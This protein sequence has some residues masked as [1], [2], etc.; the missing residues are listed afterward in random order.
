MPPERV[1]GWAARGSRSPEWHWRWHATACPSGSTKRRSASWRRRGRSWTLTCGA[2]NGRRRSAGFPRRGPISRATSGR[3]SQRNS[4]RAGEFFRATN[5][6]LRKRMEE[7]GAEI[8]NF[9]W[10][11][12]PDS[13]GDLCEMDPGN[14]SRLR[15]RLDGRME[16]IVI[17]NGRGDAGNRLS[18]SGTGADPVFFL[19]GRKVTPKR[20]RRWNSLRHRL[21]H[22]AGSTLVVGGAMARGGPGRRGEDRLEV[23]GGER[24]RTLGSGRVGAGCPEECLTIWATRPCSRRASRRSEMSCDSRR[25]PGLYQRQARDRSEI[26]AYSR[27]RKVRIYKNDAAAKRCLA[28]RAGRGRRDS[29]AQIGK[30]EP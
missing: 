19:D 18:V 10:G 11:R 14:W 29:G 28:R 4:R 9:D 27:I 24:V 3:R 20:C 8:G 23:R 15:S 30:R 1:S 22:R 6:R 13:L 2:T 12:L 17:R 26:G 21:R 16:R 5:G 25:L 7:T